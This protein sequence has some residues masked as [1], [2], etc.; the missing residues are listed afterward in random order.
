LLDKRIFNRRSLRDV[1]DLTLAEPAILAGLVH[2]PE[3][4]L[5]E[6]A[7]GNYDAVRRRRETVLDLMRESFPTLSAESL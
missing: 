4:Y 5:R 2:Q 6:I 3:A 1:Q 7:H